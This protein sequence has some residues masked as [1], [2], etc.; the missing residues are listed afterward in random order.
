[1]KNLLS[2]I[3]CIAGASLLFACQKSHDLAAPNAGEIRSTT[4]GGVGME[5]T[6]TDCGQFRTQSQGGWGVNPAGE[7]PGTYLRDHFAAAFPSGLT[8]G[9]TGGYS[10]YYSASSAVTTFL[11]AGGTA[12]V[13]SYNV[14]NPDAK[15]IKNVLIGQVTALAIN[16]AFDYADPNFAPAV[17]NFA[18]LVISSGQFAGMSVSQFLSI[19]NGVLG[20]CNTSYT[21]DAINQTASLINANFIDGTTDGGFL[22]CP[23][24]SGSR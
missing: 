4:T 13:L 24:S 16:V 1:M 10:V 19:A 17:G 3:L 9:C 14:S 12:A 18:D 6:V 21:A 11:P 7:N 20:G 8:V 15:V 23:S 2:G 22:T 5:S